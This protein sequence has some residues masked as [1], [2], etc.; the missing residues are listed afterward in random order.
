MAEQTEEKVIDLTDRQTVYSTDKDKFHE[1][2]E[3]FEVSKHI[4]DSLVKRG[5][6][7]VD[8]A[9]TKSKSE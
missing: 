1:T 5:L 6:I 3:A 8:P 7:T 2:G 4:V 9:K